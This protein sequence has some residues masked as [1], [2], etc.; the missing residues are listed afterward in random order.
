MRGDKGR[1]E[2]EIIRTGLCKGDA[3]VK[4]MKGI[5][6]LK[7]GQR[8]NADNINQFIRARRQTG[9]RR[10]QHQKTNESVGP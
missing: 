4:L 9:R 6:R 1:R 2:G 10:S 7:V 5:K 8:W 3:E